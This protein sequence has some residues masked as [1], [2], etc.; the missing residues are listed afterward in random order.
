MRR[1][2]LV[3]GAVPVLVAVG[4]ALAS[5]GSA[6]PKNLTIALTANGPSPK[7]VK[8]PAFSGVSLSFV[9]SDSVPHTVVFAGGHCSFTLPPGSGGGCNE[10]GP[11]RPGTYPYSVDGKFPGTIDVV[12]LFRSLTL[13]AGAHTIRLGS[14][15]TLLGQL[16]IA[17]E[18]APFCGL[19]ESDPIVVLARHDPSQPL[20]RIAMFPMAGRSRSKRAVNNH[21]TYSWQRRFRPGLSTTYIAKT[22][23]GLQVFKPAT[24]RPVT[25]RVRS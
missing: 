20:R 18:G 6:G 7:A 25:V 4:L 13:T 14:R 17:N 22:F 1:W 11:N 5:D 8:R 19:R 15:V 24:S 21:C 3:A 12:G 23:G 16:T 9:N 2:S 10:G